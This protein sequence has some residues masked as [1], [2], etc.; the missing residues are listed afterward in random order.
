MLRRMSPPASDTLDGQVLIPLGLVPRSIG[1]THEWK[2]LLSK[3]RVQPS[4]ALF[5]KVNFR[6]Y[7]EV[8]LFSPNV[9]EPS[10]GPIQGAISLYFRRLLWELACL[11]PKREACLASRFGHGQTGV[12]GFREEAQTDEYS[13]QTISPKVPVISATYHYGYWFW[14]PG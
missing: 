9:L 6:L 11:W 14:S 13:S 1:I 12:V 8:N 2:I 7:L 10:Q 3:A 5:L 4:P